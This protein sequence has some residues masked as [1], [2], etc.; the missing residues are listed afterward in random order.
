MIPAEVADALQ[1]ALQMPLG[2]RQ[3]RWQ[4]L[5][6]KV[7]NGSA[8][9]WCEMFLDALEGGGESGPLRPPREALR[10]AATRRCLGC[11]PSRWMVLLD[12]PHLTR[13]RFR[14]G[15]W[16][17]CRSLS[18]RTRSASSW[19]RLPPSSGPIS[20]SRTGPQAADV[21]TIAAASDLQFALEEAAA[22][23]RRNRTRPEAR[24]RV[25]GQLLPPDPQG[26]PFQLFFSA[27]EK[28]VQDLASEGLTEGE[29]DLYALGRIVIV[30][31]RGSPVKPDADLADLRAA[32]ADGRLKKFAI[33]NPEH[34]PYGRRGEEALRHAGLW[35]ALEG[36][37]VL[38]ENVSQA[39]QFALSGAAE[40][41]IVAYSLVLAPGVAARAEFTLM[42]DDW[43]Q[44][45]RQRMALLKGSG[46]NRPPVLRLHE[47]TLRAWHP[48]AL[49]LRAAR[50][51]D[52]GPGWTGRP[53]GFRC[54]S[55]Y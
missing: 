12:P 44:P 7:Q 51:D 46:E 41:G 52:V 24:L 23:F 28:F 31:P 55:E 9:R 53:S 29:G 50:R 19:P 1:R 43:H 2:E 20:S 30:A 54:S 33:A 4:A 16:L 34:A 6:E 14:E 3:E 17:P 22:F 21:P 48:Q 15:T 47:V 45:L 39:A 40:A 25:F 37:L 26:A 11:E 49:R 27:D 10:S 13:P 32:L 5:N 42:P 18:C 35:E 38:G 8:A 36:K